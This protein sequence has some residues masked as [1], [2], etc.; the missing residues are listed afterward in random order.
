MPPNG[1]RKIIMSKDFSL[2]G[3][4][5]TLVVS[6]ASQAAVHLGL[7]PHPVTGK[8][9]K[10]KNMARFNIDLLLMLQEKTKNNLTSEEAEFLTKLVQDLQLQFVQIK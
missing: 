5:S 2:E 4:F 6:I 3:S 10:D 9:E 1:E 7:A 8:T